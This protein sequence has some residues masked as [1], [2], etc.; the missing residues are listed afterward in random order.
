MSPNLSGKVFEESHKETILR[1][2]QD[3]GKLIC[4]TCDG[5]TNIKNRSIFNLMACTPLPF[6]FDSFQLDGKEESSLKLLAEILSLKK[7]ILEE[8]G[9]V[10][11][12]RVPEDKLNR[13]NWGIIWGIITD[14]PSVMRSLR[15]KLIELTDAESK[16]FWIAFGCPCHGL[17]LVMQDMIKSNPFLDSKRYYF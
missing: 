13:S 17:N 2:Q 11:E 14:N 3:N 4:L 15:S 8:L 6:F 10:G 9:P 16:V 1:L 12:V 7:R 5:L